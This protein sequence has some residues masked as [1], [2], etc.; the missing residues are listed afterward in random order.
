VQGKDD[1]SKDFLAKSPLGKVPVLDTPHGALV[2][3]NAIARYVAK[4]RRDTALDGATFFESAQVDSWMDFVAHEVEMPA[5]VWVYPI[6]GYTEFAQAPHDRAVADL[7]KALGVMEAHLTSRTFLVGNAVTLADIAAVAA[8][9]YPMKLVLDAGARAAFPCVER[10]FT[11]CVN[12]PAFAAVLGDVALA[13]VALAP[14]GAAAA[15][16][17]GGAGGAGGKGAAKKE[18]EPKA[19]A[20]PAAPKA[21]KAEKPKKKKDDDDDGEDDDDKAL[22]AEPKKADPFAALAP[23]KMNMDEWKR[24]YSNSRDDYYKSMEWFW[25]NLDAEGYALYTQE[26]KFNDENKV[27]WQTSNLVSGFLQRCDEVRKHAFGSM[28]VF[29]TAAPFVVSGVWLVR[30]GDVGIAAMLESNPDA[31]YY[32]WTKL[33]YSSAEAKKMVADFWCA[34][35]A[36]GGKTIYDSKIFK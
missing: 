29:G 18:K 30:G 10:W 1:K 25:A 19:A 28:V 12:Q 20:A 4:L 24:T 26:Y 2:E 27:D 22:Y 33:D 35:D 3:S 31:E 11:T 23:A 32:S 17:A 7:R 9:Y 14:A 8:L 16:A 36:I 15:A 34:S 6:L 21:E 13:G 5:C